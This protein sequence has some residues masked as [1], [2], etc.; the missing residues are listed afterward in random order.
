[1]SKKKWVEGDSIKDFWNF[2]GQEI[3]FWNHKAYSYAW[4]H[5]QPFRLVI[6]NFKSGSYH[7]AVPIELMNRIKEEHNNG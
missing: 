2:C 6:N 5:S 1:M 3:V 4:I 7:Y